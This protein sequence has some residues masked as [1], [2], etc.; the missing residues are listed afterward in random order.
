MKEKLYIIGAGSVGGHIAINIDQYTEKYKIAGFFDDDSE[1]IGTCKFGYM[2]L[3]KIKEI[4]EIK[5]AAVI[6][7]IAFPEVKRKIIECLHTNSGLTYPSL[8]HPK[9]WISNSVTVGQGSI[10]YPG[11]TVNFGSEISDFVVLNAN[12]TLGH[13]THVGTYSSFAPGINTGGH[14]VIEEAVDVGIGTSILQNIRVGSN[15]T[16]GGQSMITRD[17]QSNTVVVGVPAKVK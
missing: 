17:V 9:A 2:V 4:L 13:H 12:C 15:S 14:T 1:K 16:V 11:T 3:G 7:G 6:V 8:V 10:I 5:S